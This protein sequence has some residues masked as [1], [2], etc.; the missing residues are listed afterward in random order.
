MK[1]LFIFKSESFLAPIGL[2]TI[3]AAAK[4]GGHSTYLCEINSQ[5]PLRALSVLQPDIVAYS[6]S[7]GEAKHYL[8]LNRLIK[9]RSPRILTVMGGPHPTFYSDVVDEG[10]LDAV[11]VGEG[12]GAFIDLL[13]ALS[14][15]KSPEG[16][17]NIITRNGK[18]RI[19]IRGLV[20]DLDTLPFPDYDL[21]YNNTSM[22][23][24]PLKSIITSR[25]CPYNCTYCFNPAWRRHLIYLKHNPLSTFIYYMVK[26]YVLRKKIYST[27][28]SF[29]Q[30]LRIFMR[31]LRQEWFRH[32]NRNG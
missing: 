18:D 19:D 16:I 13:G 10:A 14:G 15:G 32:E 7:T 6:S 23:R 27:K 26:M 8:R 9:E 5:D 29:V 11:C 24:Y 21:I 4:R 20:E 30:S 31:S 22:G 17:P 28:T 2:C 25:G 1:V 3:S 12:E